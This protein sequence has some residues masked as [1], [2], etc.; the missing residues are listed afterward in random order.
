MSIRAA[1]FETTTG[2]KTAVDA[3]RDAG[4]TDSEISVICSDETKS[5]HFQELSE[6]GTVGE[7]ADTAMNIAGA[8]LLG[9]SG[10]A[11]L[12]TL[13]SGGAAI[14]V[15]GAFSGLAAGGTFAA[16]M[17]TRGLGSEATDFYEQALQ[18]GDLMVTV[19]IDDENPEQ[20]LA[21]AG[22]ILSQAGGD[23]FALPEG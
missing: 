7:K 6:D 11:V 20:R 21:E 18:R 17:S 13:L 14:F 5:K 8:S 22:R 19:H 23:S 4:F 10:A 16:L 2:A 15:I 1:V 3:L 12:A 9:L